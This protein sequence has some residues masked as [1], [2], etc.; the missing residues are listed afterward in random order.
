[1]DPL[2]GGG[3][4]LL[5]MA[6]GSSCLSAMGR[7]TYRTP[8]AFIRVECDVE[9]SKSERRSITGITAPRILTLDFFTANQQHHARK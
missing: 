4:R 5:V 8:Q 3:G 6:I 7:G 1:V 9:R 2:G